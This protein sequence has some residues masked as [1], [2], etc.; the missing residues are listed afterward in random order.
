MGK[1][2]SL[3]FCFNVKDKLYRDLQ[4]VPTRMSCSSRKRMTKFAPTSTGFTTNLQKHNK[5]VRLICYIII[6]TKKTK[7]IFTDFECP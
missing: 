6:E 2:F 7:M 3:S 1:K 4:S 5:T